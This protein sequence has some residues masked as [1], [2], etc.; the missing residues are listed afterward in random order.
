LL[1][2]LLVT[3]LI[4]LFSFVDWLV[5]WL[6]GWWVCWLLLLVDWLVSFVD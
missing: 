1:I 3:W 2:G 5:G 4:G 6:V